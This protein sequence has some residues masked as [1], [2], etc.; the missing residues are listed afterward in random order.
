MQDAVDT[1]GKLTKQKYR[2]EAK[3]LTKGDNNAGD[4]TEL[5]SWKTPTIPSTKCPPVR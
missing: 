1:S 3:L 5:V 2:P 4:D